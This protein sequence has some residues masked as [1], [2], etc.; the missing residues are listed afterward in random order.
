MRELPIPPA[1]HE[2]ESAV[3]IASI[4]VADKTNQFVIEPYWKDAA[5]WGILVA[6][7]IHHVSLAYERR[8]QDPDKVFA[9]IIRALRAELEKPTDFPN[10]DAPQEPHS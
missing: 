4:W 5:H 8:G 9:Q 1:A 7:L 2:A 3:E 6:D 10:D